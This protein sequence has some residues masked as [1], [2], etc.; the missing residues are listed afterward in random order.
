MG[1]LAVIVAAIVGFAVGAVWYMALSKPWVEDTGLEVDE[2]GQPVNQSA[3][4]FIMAGIAMLL[5]SGMMRHT[6]TMSGIDAPVE[7][8]I[9]GLGIGLF[10][11]SP[12]IMMNNGFGGRPFKLTLI[13]GGY[14]TI[15]C[16]IIGTILTLF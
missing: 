3:T 7:G 14:A 5:V 16:A 2:K 9:S 10:F 13:D 15:G 8:V 6:F 4:P 12:W 1:I 11:I